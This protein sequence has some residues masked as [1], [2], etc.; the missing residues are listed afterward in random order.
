M[1]EGT[2]LEFIKALY[3]LP[4]SRNRCHTH[5][6]HTLREMGFNSTHFDPYEWIRRHNR[7]YDYIGMHT[8]YVFIVAV[9]TTSIFN[10]L[11]ETY[12]IKAFG[13]PKVPL[14]CD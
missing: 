11:K 13:P 2:L 1:D 7:G 6:S 12:I 9:N 5:L 14:G 10:K 8:N 3:G 4:T